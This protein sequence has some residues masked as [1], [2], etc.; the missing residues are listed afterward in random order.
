MAFEGGHQQRGVIF[1]QIAWAVGVL[2]AGIGRAACVR[3]RAWAL[4][5][6][7]GAASVCAWELVPLQGAAAAAAPPPA[8]VCA[9]AL[10]RLRC[11]AATAACAWRLAGGAAGRRCSV[12]RQRAFCIFL[13]S[14]VYAGVI[15]F[16]KNARGFAT[17]HFPRKGSATQVD[18]H[19]PVSTSTTR[20]SKYQPATP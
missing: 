6:L 1:L 12:P 8:A 3:V 19:W 2:P 9:W 16:C 4:A 13:L 11:D 18:S 17:V 10:V 14:G 7:Q 15:N 20:I 5:P